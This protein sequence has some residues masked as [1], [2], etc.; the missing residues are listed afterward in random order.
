MPF[1]MGIFA[2]AI[3]ANFLIN[4]FRDFGVGTYLIREASLTNEKIRT[5]FGLSIMI[6]WSLGIFIVFLAREPLADVYNEP[7]IASVLLLTSF[8]FFVSPFG[9]PAA[10]LLQREMQFKILHHVTVIS[11]LLGTLTSIGLAVLE[12]SYM[13]L[14][15]GMV[16]GS[17][18]RTSLIL[19]VRR[20]HLALLPGLR[21]WRDVL[22][23]GGWLT[24]AGFFG[25]VAAEGRKFIIG[26]FLG[27]AALAL[28][29]RAQQVPDLSRQALFLPV[30]RV[31]LPSLSK[32]IREG[33]SIGPT[34][35]TLI[36][37]T[38]VLVWPLFLSI[39][40]L[41]VPIIEIVFGRNWTIAGEILPY[42]LFAGV[43]ASTLPQPEQILVPQGFVR[44]LAALRLL[45][46]VL[47]LGLGLAGSLHS[48]ELLAFLS[49][50]ATA[51]FML[52]NYFAIRRHIG[53]SL[54]RLA[55]S[56][57]KSLLIAL[58]SS[59]GPLAVFL[60]YGASVPIHLVV[61]ALI[62][63]FLM[64]LFAVFAVRHAL[65]REMSHVI[66]TLWA[67]SS[68]RLSKL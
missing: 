57:F 14:A 1:E 58:W 2:L 19:L 68:D 10:A 5:V 36:G 32:D 4:S 61:L 21:H 6:Q 28:V 44:R 18:V 41:S 43:I 15:W 22:G 37:F 66:G 31:L 8:T 27:P 24:V 11:A 54:R 56:Y 63:A 23:F 65:S 59:L 67:R 35:E 7:G 52:L 34:I 30:A 45:Q 47:F 51:I 33:R 49:T 38:T 25:T 16:V 40:L 64:W 50:V 60:E 9:Q 46:T 20:D 12:F 42:Y 62:S 17:L 13:A 39:S 48:L 53:T 55:P 26:G 29:E 3:A